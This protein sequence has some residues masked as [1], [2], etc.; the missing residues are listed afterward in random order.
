MWRSFAGRGEGLHNAA[1]PG[2]K[3][4]VYFKQVW[5]QNA[6]FYSVPL[7]CY[8]LTE[9]TGS[10]VLFLK[11]LCETYI[12]TWLCETIDWG[13][14]ITKIQQVCLSELNRFK[15]FQNYYNYKNI[16]DI[17]RV[18]VVCKRQLTVINKKKCLNI[19]YYFKRKRHLCW[20]RNTIELNLIV[21]QNWNFFRW[22]NSQ[23]QVD[24]ITTMINTL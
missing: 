20:H 12:K 8:I 10:E 7:F 11:R 1:H 18:E 9:L 5:K 16:F 14:V 6:R 15:Y 17:P 13:R 2:V 21:D 24:E 3:L 22:Q 19:F 23:R 4:V